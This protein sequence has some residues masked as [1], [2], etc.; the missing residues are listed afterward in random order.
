MR[1]V[2]PQGVRLAL[3]VGLTLAATGAIAAPLS[4]MSLPAPAPAP[5]PIPVPLPDPAPAP[6]KTPA[7]APSP[8]PART[9]LLSR[10]DGE[11]IRV[12]WPSGHRIVAPA[13]TVRVGVSQ[14]RRGERKLTVR[15]LRVSA[16]GRILGSVQRTGVT[17]GTVSVA[18]PD[19]AGRR[20]ALRLQ[21]GGK[22]L[23]SLTIRTPAAAPVAPAPAP[24]VPGPSWPGCPATAADPTGQIEF[25]APSIVAGEPLAFAVLNT[26]SSCFAPVGVVGL[27]REDAGAWT[28]VPMLSLAVPAIYYTVPSGQRDRSAVGT[29]PDAQP[30]T[31]RVTVRLTAP[32]EPGP[33]A[34]VPPSTL[35]QATF[36]VTAPPAP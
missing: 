17:R 29:L 5:A 31:Y 10:G 36:E 23:R 15:L 22:L 8:G 24:V 25:S 21:R 3:G 33:T 14:P 11:R 34:P 19:A 4:A 27:E 30:G 6:P 28:H 32:I 13:S 2:R 12:S 20:Y 9:L 18:I 1:T 7:P 16:K 26:G 35:I